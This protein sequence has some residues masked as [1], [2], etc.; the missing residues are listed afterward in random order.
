[1]TMHLLCHINVLCTSKDCSKDCGSSGTLV[2][3]T[4]CQCIGS[5]VGG[6]VLYY[7][8]YGDYYGDYYNSRY[9]PIADVKV[10]V[11]GREWKEW[12]RSNRD[13]RYRFV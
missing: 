2:N 7:E 9:H 12:T 8:Y 10:Y 1:M 5:D 11:V 3:C 6:K 4:V 13:G